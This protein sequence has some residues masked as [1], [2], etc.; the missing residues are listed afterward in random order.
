MLMLGGSQRSNRDHDGSNDFSQLRT[1]SGRHVSLS[2]PT[3]RGHYI[4]AVF[5]G[6]SSERSLKGP[7]EFLLF[8]LLFTP[9]NSVNE[10][11]SSS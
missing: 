2:S 8:V 3:I 6:R 9:L 1:K 10:L 4:G 11:G 7:Y 5:D